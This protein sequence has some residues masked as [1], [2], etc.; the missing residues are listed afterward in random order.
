MSEMDRVRTRLK[1]R[2]EVHSR[3]NVLLSMED[4]RRIV[5][6]ICSE[7]CGEFPT[8]EAVEHLARE[9]VDSVLEGVKSPK[10]FPVQR[11]I[12]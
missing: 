10:R 12:A 5:H 7:E 11:G 8:G 6:H 2:A 3:A 4:A 1:D 9:L